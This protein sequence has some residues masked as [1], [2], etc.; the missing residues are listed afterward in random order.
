MTTVTI[1][2]VEYE[3]VN[4]EDERLMIA[5]LDRGFVIVGKGRLENNYWHFRDVSCVRRWGT[6][7][8]LGELAKNGPLPETVLD[9]Q[10]ATQVHEL[11]TVQ[12]I[13]CEVE[14]WTQ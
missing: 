2:G 5:V 12:I 4:R 3:P 9:P 11:Q 10:P 8:G 1:D 7:K 13:D 6:T 14:K